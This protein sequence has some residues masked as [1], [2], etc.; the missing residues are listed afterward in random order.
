MTLWLHLQFE[1]RLVGWAA[2]SGNV[3]TGGAAE[4]RLTCKMSSKMSS[5]VQVAGPAHLETPPLLLLQA[6]RDVIPRRIECGGG[7]W[8]VER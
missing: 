3:E 1:V 2:G 8:R 6:E 4:P 5:V 7:E